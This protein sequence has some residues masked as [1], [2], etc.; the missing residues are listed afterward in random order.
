MGDTSFSLSGLLAKGELT[1][2]LANGP[3]MFVNCVMYIDKLQEMC[4]RLLCERTLNCRLR[5]GDCVMG[6]VRLPFSSQ[7]LMLLCRESG[8]GVCHAVN[9]SGRDIL[10][11]GAVTLAPC[12]FIID[13][14]QV[15]TEGPTRHE[16]S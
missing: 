4:Q 7:S 5:P 6:E 8:D 10:H 1:T 11:E 13:S 3:F 15:P 2:K 12:T 14:S 16:H 9:T